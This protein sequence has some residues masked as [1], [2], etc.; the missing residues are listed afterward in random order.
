MVADRFSSQYRRYYNYLQPILAD[1]VVRSYFSLIASFLLVAFLVVFALSPTINTILG[2]QK[3]INDQ[4]T[5]IS[6]LDKKSNDLLK[7]N[8]AY[9][10]VQ[11]LIPLLND[12]LPIE[13]FP[14]KVTSDVNLVASQS[15]VTLSGPQFQPFELNM[16][17]PTEVEGLGKV[18]ISFTISGPKDNVRNFLAKIENTLR[19]I[20]IEG[21]IVGE[22]KKP[23]TII[24]DISAI[25]YYLPSQQ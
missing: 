2:L 1:P 24:M 3:K 19:Y 8:E 7:A 15:A 11:T 21:L 6:T 12:A 4:R 16:D 23:G 18:K 9:G 5:I 25:N 14:A 22:S 13:P 20:R 17:T 10:Q